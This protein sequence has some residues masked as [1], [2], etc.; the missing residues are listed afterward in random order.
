MQHRTGA[1]WAGIVDVRPVTRPVSQS[2]Q[3][4]G[5][6]WTLSEYSVAGLNVVEPRLRKWI[7][8]KYSR[9]KLGGNSRDLSW[10]GPMALLHKYS[11]FKLQGSLQS[12]GPSAPIRLSYK[13]S[14][15]KFCG[16]VARK[17]F[18]ANIIMAQA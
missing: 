10:T 11:L 17:T 3:C 8:P 12:Q 18:I 16:S 2:P 6:R 5:S 9:T 1:E 14:S 4:C 13:C 7:S 15:S